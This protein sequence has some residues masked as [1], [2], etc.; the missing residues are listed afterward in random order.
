MLSVVNV[1]NRYAECHHTECHYVECH[2]AECRGAVYTNAPFHTKLDP[3]LLELLGEPLELLQVQVLIGGQL[4]PAQHGLVGRDKNRGQRT[5][6]RKMGHRRGRRGGGG[7]GRGGPGANVIKLYT[8][9][10]TLLSA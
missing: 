6:D 1:K 9:V 10:I 8:A 7:G 5:V 2:Y 4:Q 3:P